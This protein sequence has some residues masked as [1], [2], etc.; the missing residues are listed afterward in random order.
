MLTPP[1][2]GAAWCSHC[3]LAEPMPLREAIAH[4]EELHT[5]CF[6]C[7]LENLLFQWLLYDD[8]LDHAPRLV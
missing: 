7:R 1:R 3:D 2:P 8:P 4:R 5:D 6:S